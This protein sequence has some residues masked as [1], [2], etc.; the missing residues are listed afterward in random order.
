MARKVRLQYPGA[1]YRWMSRI[2]TKGFWKREIA[3]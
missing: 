3:R 1:I 2:G